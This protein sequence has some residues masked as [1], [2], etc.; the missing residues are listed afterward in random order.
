M[1][2][3]TALRERIEHGKA[4]TE[5]ER[6]AILATFDAAVAQ[7]V[8]AMSDVRAAIDGSYRDQI[9]ADDATIGEPPVEPVPFRQAAE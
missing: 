3:L 7:F 9:A 2:T 8:T 5:T 4:Q 6:Q 1:T